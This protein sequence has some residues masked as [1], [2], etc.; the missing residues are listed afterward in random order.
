MTVKMR[1]RIALGCALGV[2]LA[3]A[4]A[5]SSFAEAQTVDAPQS[6]DDAWWT[7]PLV[8]YSAHSLPQGHVLIEP[9]FYDVSA[10]RADSFHSFTYF[11]YGA[12]DRLTVG[13]APD[14]AFTS[15]RGAPDSS[16]VHLGD[17]TLRAQYMLLAMDPAQGIPDLAL[18]VLQTLPTGKYDR[19]DRASDGFGGGSYATTVAVYSQMAWWLPN[20][21]LLRTRFNVS[22]TFSPRVPVSDASVY[23][24]DAG[25][26][27]HAQPGN[28]FSINAAFEY[29]LTRNWVPALD[30]IYSHGNATIA[31]GF[32]AAKSVRL[33]S[34]TSDAFGFAPALEYNW[35]ANLGVLAGVRIFPASHNSKAS[36]TPALAINYVI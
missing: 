8:S 15:A 33:D 28:Q 20:G 25:F 1:T 26:L 17:T 18:A 2:A 10:N 5:A 22:E 13:V 23:G 34:D 6:L 24:T 14:I 29:S 19:L 35:T 7:G 16:G 27:G 36:V 11:L 30:L 31:Q 4:L 32:D 12:T 9:Y 3:A 21:R